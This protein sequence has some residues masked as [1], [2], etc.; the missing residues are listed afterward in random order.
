MDHITASEILTLTFLSIPALAM[1]L[2]RISRTCREGMELF[3]IPPLADFLV[4]LGETGHEMQRSN[5]EYL[6][7]HGYLTGDEHP[8][9]PAVPSPTYTV[10]ED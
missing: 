1:I 10:K 2:Y 4:G 7:E 8:M 9:V 6:A 3:V 5:G